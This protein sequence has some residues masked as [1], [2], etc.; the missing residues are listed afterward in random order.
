MDAFSSPTASATVPVPPLVRPR[1]TVV[2][3]TYDEAGNIARTV[4][5]IFAALDGIPAE[6]LVV[7]DDSP[8]GT[9]RIAR[10]LGEADP[11]VRT[12]R[13][14]GRRGLSGACIEGMLAASAPVVAVIDADLQHDET[15]LPAML[16]AVEEG[17]A[18]L[19]VGTRFGEGAAVEGGL[20]ARRALAS[21]AANLATR[22]LLG[23]RLA[24]PMS[25]YFCL[26]RETVERLAPRLAPHGFKILADIVATA[27]GRLRVAEFPFVFRERKAG[28]SKLDARVGLEFL[29]LV[30]S[31]LT[32][33]LL[34]VRFVLFGMVGSSGILV[35]MAALAALFAAGLAFAA[36]QALATVVAMTSNFFLNNWLTFRDRRL[37]GLG[38]LPGLLSFYAVC[39]LGVVANVGVADALFAAD[40]SWWL[41]GLA[42]ALVGAVWNYTASA[43]VTWRA[44]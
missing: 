13:R 25:G 6:I 41:A 40:R 35:H 20:S 5:R 33:G 34:S 3:P 24:D 12:L 9:W 14:V 1:L 23:V 28:T 38:L 37:T 7:D 2:V 11:R 15:L 30:A 44:R 42:G 21:R 22:V 27:R 10:R 32:G 39:G 8:D 31:R 17:R 43:V 18:D 19:A 26:R 29:A 4:A 16:E 36:A